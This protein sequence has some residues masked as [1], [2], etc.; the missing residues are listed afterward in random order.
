MKDTDSPF[1]SKLDV[2]YA[3]DNHTF[4]VSYKDWLDIEDIK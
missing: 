4:I 1:I 2:E 3:K